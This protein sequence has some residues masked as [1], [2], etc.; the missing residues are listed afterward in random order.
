MS[1]SVDINVLPQSY[2]DNI[3][4]GPY[5][6][7]TRNIECSLGFLVRAPLSKWH[8]KITFKGVLQSDDIKPLELHRKKDFEKLCR[9]IDIESL[10]PSLLHDTVTEIILSNILPISC[11]EPLYSVDNTQFRYVVDNLEDSACNM[12]ARIAHRVQIIT[13]REDPTRMRFLPC[14]N[15][16]I[17]TRDLTTIRKERE[18]AAGVYLA[19]IDS[20]AKLYIYKTLNRPYYAPE[21]TEVLVYELQNL[22]ALQ[23]VQGI[24]R[25]LAIVTSVNPDQTSESSQSTAVGQGLLLEYHSNGTL[26]DALLSPGF[27]PWKRWALQIASSLHQMHQNGL[28]HMDIKP[29]NI[30]IN[31]ILTRLG[32]KGSVFGAKSSPSILSHLCIRLLSCECCRRLNRYAYVYILF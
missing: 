7:P 4:Q 24:V 29:L 18:L 16:H 12:F 21:I 8:V 27:H 20:D 3:L 1:P 13:L 14:D 9:S 30:V 5:N 26:R 2:S 6:E 11:T 19:Y 23:D 10:S 31:L 25:L 17:P 22:V 28:T 15:R 32:I